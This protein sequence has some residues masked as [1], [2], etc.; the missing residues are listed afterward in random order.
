MNFK[1][2]GLKP[3]LVDHLHSIGFEE[4]TEIQQKVIQYIQTSGAPKKDL[5]ALAQTGTG[6]TAA[7]SLPLLEQIDTKEKK[8]Q[9]LILSPTRELCIQIQKDI[10]LFSKA[11]KGVSSI[12]VYGGT[13][14]DRQI[15]TLRK[16]PQVIVATPGRCLDLIKRKKLNTADIG[17]VVFDEADEMLNMGFKP[18]IDAILSNTTEPTIWLFSAT[19]SKEVKRIASKY[20]NDA[21]EITAQTQNSTA[22]NLE[23][24]YY[25][26]AE[27]N[28]YAALKR[29]LDFNPHIFGLIF[30]RTKRDTQKTAERLIEDGYN[31]APIHGDLTQHQRDSVMKSFRSRALQILVA[32][33]VAARG[34]DVDKIT[35]VINYQ[36]PDDLETY[37]HRSGRT[38]RAGQSG[39]SIA[40]INS[41]ENR[42]IRDIE[43]FA[44]TEFKKQ[45]IPNGEEICQAQLFDLVERIK[46][47]NVDEKQIEPFLLTASERLQD[48]DSEEIIKRFFAVEFNKFL[49]YYKNAPDL[50]NIRE[51]ESRGDRRDSRRGDRRDSRRGEKRDSRRGDRREGF[52][53]RSRDA[54][55]DRFFYRHGRQRRHQQRFA[56][57]KSL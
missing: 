2:L 34:I 35:H 6:K 49:E 3:E 37:T 41:R 24:H 13:S 52:N 51:R 8:P 17:H 15:Q 45:N 12:A 55:F 28:R 5:V 25:V 26:V 18:D 53:S 44:N 22:K 21:H 4:A 39:I 9:A 10:D 1:D 50:N 42:K 40:L 56:C 36:L 14:I 16:G 31:S 23:H 19:M 43:R 30:C 20:M 46:N 38:A 32:T 29:I 54:A 7:F 11:Y 57:T 48:F 47:A 33:D 27:K